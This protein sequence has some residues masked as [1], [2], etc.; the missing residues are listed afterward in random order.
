MIPFDLAVPIAIGIKKVN[1]RNMR[2][3]KFRAWDKAGEY[4][5]PL[6]DDG[7]YYFR[8]DGDGLCLYDKW[9][10]CKNTVL[11]QFTGLKDKNG[12]EIYEGDIIKTLTG[13][14]YEVF[15]CEGMV[16][17]RLANKS[18]PANGYM[19]ST[20]TYDEVIGNIYENPEL[21]T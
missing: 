10:E 12:K 20:S 16:S 19:Y 3:I 15:W 2:E 7:D 8:D 5:K 4:F 21:I 17:F 13:L 11:M 14:T 1:N 6:D 9:G 18:T